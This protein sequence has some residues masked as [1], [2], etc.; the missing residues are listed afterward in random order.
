MAHAEQ[1]NGTLA[2]LIG[3]LASDISGL[4][5][6]EIQ[7]AKAEAS[8]KLDDALKAGR[9]L[10]IGA[11]LAIGAIGVFL[12]ALV[13]GLAALLVGLGMA[14]QP[15]NFVAALVITAAVG[16]IAWAF[17][18]RG[19]AEFKANKLNMERTAHSLQMDA[20]AVK[21]SI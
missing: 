3:G 5:R 7:L 16:A 2:D 4:F 15:A 11:V 18:A 20:A 17:T 10:A 14:E 12:A 8:E 9:N 21:E 1:G 6:K 19:I 13:A